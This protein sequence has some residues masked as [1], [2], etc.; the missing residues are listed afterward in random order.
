[1]S[2][3]VIGTTETMEGV[4]LTD[5]QEFYEAVFAPNITN[6]VIVG[7]IEKDEIL[8]KLDFLK[9]WEQKEISFPEQPASPEAAA[10]KIF[11]VDKPGAAQSEIRMGY[12]SMPYDASGEYYKA[13]QMNFILGGAFNSRINLS[14]RE[15]HGWTY[16]AFSYFSGNENVGPFTA[17]AGVKKE[18][19][20]S[21]VVEFLD[22]LKD[23]AENGITEDELEFTKSS[24]GQKDAL[25]YEAGYQKTGFLNKILR[26]DL[27][28]DFTDKQSD[29]LQ[30]L[31]KEDIDA[32]AAKHVDIDKMA[33]VV[34][35]DKESIYEGLSKLPYEIEVV[36]LQ[37]EVADN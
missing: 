34:V 7:D 22:I 32:L 23:Y 20:D 31:T 6:M 18:A 24:V 16:G 19:T 4:T 3:P 27:A 33:I 2:I 9:S 11:L 28:S 10:T 13:R 30:G 14:L 35:G 17:Q 1:M 25:K 8:A 36:N 26:F 29:I 21:S 12:L 5:V 15:K 37:V